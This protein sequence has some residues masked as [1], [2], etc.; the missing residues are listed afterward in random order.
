MFFSIF[1]RTARAVTAVN[2]LVCIHEEN[3]ECQIVIE[4]EQRQIQVIRFDQA[5][6]DK[7]VKQLFKFTFATDNLP[8]KAV[9]GVSWDSAKNNHQR[10]LGP[11]SLFTGRLEIV[12]NPQFV[13]VECVLVGNNGCISLVLNVLRANRYSSEQCHDNGQ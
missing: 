2:R 10:L 8:I 6:T 12:I 7:L 3:G 9:A 5:H 13:L 1:D 4:L 11:G